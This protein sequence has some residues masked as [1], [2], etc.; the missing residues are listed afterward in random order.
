VFRTPVDRH[1]S[2]MLDFTVID[3]VILMVKRLAREAYRFHDR[4]VEF[5]VVALRAVGIAIITYTKML[6]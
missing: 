3:T 4:I 1:D 2:G 5:V 6:F